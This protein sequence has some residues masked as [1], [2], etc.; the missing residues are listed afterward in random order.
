MFVV[1]LTKSAMDKSKKPATSYAPFPSFI[2]RTPHN[3]FQT[4]AETI[5]RLEADENHW[6]NFLQDKTLQEAIF[7]GSPV[8]YDEIQKFLSGALTAPKEVNKL[9]MSVLR[10]Y[11]RMS[12]RCTPFGLFAGFSMGEIEE[13]LTVLRSCSCFI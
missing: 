4:F 11:T 7:L 12:T 3:S 13:P 5:A 10:Y 6:H 9:K 8:L 2:F 1:E